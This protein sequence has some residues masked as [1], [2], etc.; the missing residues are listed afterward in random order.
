M[1]KLLLFKYPVKYISNELSHSIIN[2]YI[3][4]YL[5][6]LGI[7]VNDSIGTYGINANNIISNNIFKPINCC[8]QEVLHDDI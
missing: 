8:L 1:T 6:K 5:E 3:A 2:N 7:S 4:E